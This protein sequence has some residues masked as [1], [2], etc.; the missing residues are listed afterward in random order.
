MD[1]ILNKAD[2]ERLAKPWDHYPEWEYMQGDPSYYP[3]EPD[4]T[5]WRVILK[6]VIKKSEDAILHWEVDADPGQLSTLNSW[7]SNTLRDFMVKG[8]VLQMDHEDFLTKV[9]EEVNEFRKHTMKSEK[10]EKMEATN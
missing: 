5:S 6:I 9:S 3:V 2:L 1:G 8:G 4:G 10:K 7:Q